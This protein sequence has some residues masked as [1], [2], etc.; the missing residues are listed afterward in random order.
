VVLQQDIELC[1][2]LDDLGLDEVW[3]VSTTPA[4]GAR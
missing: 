2:L 4:A 1:G 3:R